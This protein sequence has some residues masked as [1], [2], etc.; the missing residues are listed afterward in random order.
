MMP[1]PIPVNRGGAFQGS[2]EPSLGQ[3]IQWS[4]SLPVETTVQIGLVS[5]PR[6]ASWDGD[7]PSGGYGR[8]TE[9][10]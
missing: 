5:R 10:S 7:E 2:E 8:Q 4:S 1:F 9:Q 6:R 3:A